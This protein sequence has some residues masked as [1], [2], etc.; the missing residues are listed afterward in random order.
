MKAAK[1]LGINKEE[2]NE[3]QG[4]D[5]DEVGEV[6]LTADG[7]WV[8]KVKSIEGLENLCS[9]KPKEV[10]QQIWRGVKPVLGQ[11]MKLTTMTL[12]QN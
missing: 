9:L 4:W 5:G 8:N 10:L 1:K 11:L 7:R 12:L 3:V 2:I 6:G